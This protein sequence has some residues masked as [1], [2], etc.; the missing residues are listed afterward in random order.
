MGEKEDKTEIELFLQQVSWNSSFGGEASFWLAFLL[1][2]ETH[3]FP[4]K[5]RT[6]RCFSGLR[7][8]SEIPGTLIPSLSDH[9]C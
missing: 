6:T 1:S 4:S 9:F 8:C 5:D 3:L 2:I 7:A